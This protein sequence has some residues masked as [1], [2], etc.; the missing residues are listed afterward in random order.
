MNSVDVSANGVRINGRWYW[1]E[2]LY[3]LRGTVLCRKI[4]T[5]TVEIYSRDMERICTAAALK[6]E[7]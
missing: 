1:N 4:N 6:L 7:A 3:G 5:D 2:A